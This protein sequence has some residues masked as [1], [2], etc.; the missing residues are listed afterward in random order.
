MSTPLRELINRLADDSSSQAAF[1]ADP[2]GFLAEHGWADLDGQDVGTALGA[3]ADEAPID[4]AVRLGEV[5]AE[6]AIA[7]LG[8]AAA[9]F[10]ENGELADPDLTL[11]RQET[12]EDVEGVDRDPSDGIDDGPDGPDRLDEADDELDTSAFRSP[13]DHEGDGEE[14]AEPT[15]EGEPEPDEPDIPLGD[16]TGGI[17]EIGEIG[18]IDEGVGHES[19]VDTDDGGDAVDLPDPDDDDL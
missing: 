5:E 12:D 17:D 10:A 6:D 7:G 8:A 15:V 9:V 13:A 18:E 19:F 3:L 14:A 1:A 4:Q 16:P 11:D 2:A